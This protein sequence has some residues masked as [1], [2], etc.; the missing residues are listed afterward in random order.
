MTYNFI[1]KTEFD[2][3]LNVKVCPKKCYFKLFKNIKTLIKHKNVYNSLK[4]ML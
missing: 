1:L 2:F 4:K 3:I